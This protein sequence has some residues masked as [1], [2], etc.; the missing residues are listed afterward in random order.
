MNLIKLN[1]IKPSLVKLNFIKLNLIT[2]NHIELNLII[3]NLVSL[4]WTA[5]DDRDQSLRARSNYRSQVL[6]LYWRSPE[7]GGVW[8]R[9][10]QLRRTI[11]F[12]SGGWCFFFF[13]F[14]FVTP[15]TGPRRPQSLESSDAKV[16][17]RT[18]PPQIAS[19]TRIRTL[20]VR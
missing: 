1:L 3:L 16:Y 13:F 8:Y 6:D 2:L 9:S 4:N 19:S 7:S 5:V 17:E 14:F 11:C 18:S 12:P 20:K 10:R 15:R